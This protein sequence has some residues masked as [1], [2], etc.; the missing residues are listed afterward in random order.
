MHC[1]IEEFQKYHRPEIRKE[2]SDQLKYAGK[3]TEKA[4]LKLLMELSIYPDFS[5]C[6]YWYEDCH[7]DE[8]DDWLS[9][10]LGYG[11]PTTQTWI[12]VEGI[13]YGWYAISDDQEANRRKL[14]ELIK[15]NTEYLIDVDFDIFEGKEFITYHFYTSEGFYGFDTVVTINKLNDETLMY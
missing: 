8:D 15:R 3:F 5:I 11:D 2:Y 4:R 9:M 12:D 7:E 10:P 13:G 6:D 14:F 1:K